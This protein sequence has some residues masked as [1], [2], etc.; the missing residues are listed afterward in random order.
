MFFDQIRALD[1]TGGRSQMESGSELVSRMKKLSQ[2]TPRSIE[3]E[4]FSGDLKDRLNRIIIPLGLRSIDRITPKEG[5]ILHL[6]YD[7][8]SLV[9]DIN[10][11]GQ[12]FSQLVIVLTNLIL[13]KGNFTIICLEEPESSLHPGL[14][15]RFID[16][17]RTF[18]NVEF[19][20][21]THS[22]VILDCLEPADKVFRL[23]QRQDGS[24]NVQPC[25]AIQEQH[26]LLDALGIRA[27]SLLQTNCVIWVEEPTDRL[28]LRRM[29]KC[30]NPNL[31]EGKNYTFNFYGGTILSHFE[32]MAD[33]ELTKD[34]IAMLCISRYAIV[35]M[36][37]DLRPDDHLEKLSAR[38]K[39]ILENAKLDPDHR[40]AFITDG[41]EIEND[42]PKVPFLKGCAD[43]T[44]VQYDTV[45]KQSL[46]GTQEYQQEFLQIANINDSDKSQKLLRA[47]ND[48]QKLAVAVLKHWDL[49]EDKEIPK[50]ISEIVEMI[51]R[52][53]DRH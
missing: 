17:L 4:R 33:D 48:K 19:L 16:E 2:D 10:D 40:L 51:R 38:K 3:W 23:Q 52:S 15:R 13:R 42:V 43:L 7:N 31:K 12:G 30:I 21:T 25:H 22:H 20:V 50:Y 18:K 41:R 28:Y 9:T 49:N 32:L 29:I 45:E 6:A 37:R 46:T 8:P 1:R 11:I 24:C 35:L 47:L 27:S 53:E 5:N 14:L 36:D 39:R 26:A 44:K 34:L